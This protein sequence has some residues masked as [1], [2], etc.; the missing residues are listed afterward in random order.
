MCEVISGLAKYLRGVVQG[1]PIRRASLAA[2]QEE[3]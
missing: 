1:R 2:M 3:Y